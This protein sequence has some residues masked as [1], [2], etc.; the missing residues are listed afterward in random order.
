MHKI[1]FK[2]GFNNTIVE[3][4]HHFIVNGKTDKPIDENKLSSGERFIFWGLLWKYLNENKIE[5]A[6]ENFKCLFLLDEP[7]S[8][9]N[10]SAIENFMNIIKEDLV[11]G[12]KCQ[13]I[14]TT[15]NLMT[16]NFF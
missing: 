9:L 5:L 14:M 4:N 8:H 10:Q 13:V 16:A 7:D 12:L 1:G 2:N 6:D 11:K 15:H 3:V